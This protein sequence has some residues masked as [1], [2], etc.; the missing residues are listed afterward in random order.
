MTTA[1]DMLAKGAGDFTGLIAIVLFV[2]ITFLV[3]VIRNVLQWWQKKRAEEEKMLHPEP[4]RK[5]A[6]EAEPAPSQEPKRPE[7]PPA[8]AVQDQFA[9]AMR[10]FLG[11]VEAQA[12]PYLPLV[13]LEH[14]AVV[15][16]AQAS[17]QQR[18]V[19]LAAR[20]VGLVVEVDVLA[21]VRVWQKD[22]RAGDDDR[23]RRVLPNGST[24]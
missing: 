17:E 13:L 2:L 18:G 14:Q 6:A 9:R 19:Q 16:G 23:G 24:R 5:Q 7:E 15:A 22:E 21:D 11:V 4:A 12:E 20:L 3:S 8:R 1:A 10:Q